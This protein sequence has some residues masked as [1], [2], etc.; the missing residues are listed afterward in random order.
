MPFRIIIPVRYASTRLPGKPLEDIAGK[1]MVQH[2]Y[3]RCLD[4]GAESVV[5]ATDDEKVRAACEGFG[6]DVCMTSPDNASGTERLAEAV[7]ALG[8]EDDEI[9]VN[10]QGDEPLIPPGLIRQVA[11]DLT[12]HDN[13]KVATLCEEITNPEDVFNPGVVKVV[14]NKRGFA[15]YFSRAPIPY[16]RDNFAQEPRVIE[17]PHYRHIGIY[18]YRVGFLEEYL[19]WELSPVGAKEELEQLRVLW[20]CGRIHVTIAKDSLAAGVDTPEDL[21]RV[22]QIFAKQS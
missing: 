8:Y 11:E 6:A 10:V 14:T 17:G 18:A 13:T 15:L 16:E 22:R 7:G 21:E 19:Q 20:N 4:S 3:E 9:V 1:P 12:V 5:V 2:V